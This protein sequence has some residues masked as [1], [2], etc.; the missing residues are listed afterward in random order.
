[1]KR[2]LSVVVA[3]LLVSLG[4]AIGLRIQNEPLPAAAQIV[5][6]DRDHY[7]PVAASECVELVDKG[8]DMYDRGLAS[9]RA[10]LE[11][12][13]SAVEES[14][15]EASKSIREAERLLPQLSKSR[16]AFLKQ[17]RKCEEAQ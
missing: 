17:A 3:V 1:M 5:Y 15:A 14:Y 16:K 9:D 8:V 6:K 2:L 4:L 10:T 11:A 13:K 12:A 7:I